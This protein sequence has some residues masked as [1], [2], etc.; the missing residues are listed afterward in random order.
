M[1]NKKYS[2][3]YLA[4]LNYDRFF[5]KAFSDIKIAK[6]FIED[7][8]DIEIQEIKELKTDRK[9]ITD[10]AQAVEFD[11]YCK[12]DNQYVII[13]MQQWRKHDIV[14]RFYIYH[15]IG[16]VLQLE[17][18]P[19]KEVLSKKGKL[20]KI[21]DYSTLT[22]VITIIWLVEDDLG[23]DDDYISY[24]ML[25]EKTKE[26]FE[27]TE[28]W[29]NKNIEQKVKEVLKNL[30]N[31]NSN[32]SFLSKNRLI[33][34]F[35]QNIVKNKKIS[36]YLPWFQIANKSRK[37]DNKK[38]DF[39]EFRI[40]VI[41][42]ELMRR[43]LRSD[44]KE[45]DLEYIISEEQTRENIERYNKGIRKEAELKKHEAELKMQKAE[46]EKH[47]AELK[48]Q[49]AE[50]E[51]HEE[52]LKRQK[53]EQEKQEETLKRQ[54]AEQEKHK[55]EQEKHEEKVKREKA[56]IFAKIMKLK[57]IN[58]LDN[59]TIAKKLEITNQY[60]EKVLNL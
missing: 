36:K 31:N 8:L 24:S 49:K 22:P 21:K 58:K 42:K 54:K 33:F 13:D 12:I 28:I 45:D 46:Q 47:K 59:E 48:M 5:K 44:L 60:I 37:S 6:K 40:D 39:D 56:E 53:A 51:K 1:K 32:L 23:T 25:P 26:F 2:K 17:H 14:Y 30:K 29:K 7:F 41:F 34:A 3:A 57:F 43:L 38:S 10:D 15:C 11:Y 18:L 27:Q 9:K 20:E 52:T 4:P 55:A 50:Q 35:Q 19:L 16:S